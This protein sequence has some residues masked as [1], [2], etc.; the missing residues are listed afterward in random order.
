MKMQ[1]N[2]NKHALRRLWMGTLMI[3]SV[4]V[5]AACGA[6]SGVD[7][8]PADDLS[9]DEIT[10]LL[11]MREEEKLARDVYL[12]LYE[13]WELPIFQNIANSEQSHMD[14]IA[15][16]LDRYGLED[17][18]AGQDIGEFT[19]GDL[20]ALYDELV[21]TGSASLEE[22]L[23][24]GAAIEEIDILDLEEYIAET[25]RTD[26]I[27]VYENLL[28]GSRNHLRSFA[29][30]LERQTGEV[31]TPQYLTQE[32]YDDIVNGSVETGRGT[33]GNGGGRGGR[34]GRGG[35]RG[36]RS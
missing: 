5:L 11:F 29:R 26:I 18:A 31:Y 7:A 21:A 20:Q 25:D 6:A 28:R 32:A 27:Q 19:N 33:Q 8:A 13:Q 14:A 10:G 35:G 3:M 24:V 16:L 4:L 22:A 23:R 12:T 9:E 1:L 17:P 36:Y 34:G 30:T 2:R 15:T